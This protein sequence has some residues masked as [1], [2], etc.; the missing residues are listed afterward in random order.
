MKLKCIIVDDEPVARKLLR[1]Y[2]SDTPFLELVGEA[3]NPL[4]IQAIFDREPIDLIFLDINMP[5]LTGLEFLR[6]NNS[7]LIVIKTIAYAEH[8]F[9]GFELAVLDYLIKPFS[10]ERFLKGCNKAKDYHRLQIQKENR[11]EQNEK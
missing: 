11:S 10:F 8:A 4:K 2:I 3:E 9:D 6:S 5:K 7:L 1:E